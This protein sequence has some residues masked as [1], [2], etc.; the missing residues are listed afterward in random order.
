ASSQAR[1]M[2]AAQLLERGFNSNSN[3]LNWLTPSPGVVEAIEPIHEEPPNLREDM[4]GAHRK[5]KA[6]EDED[7]ALG[8]NQEPDSPYGVFPASL[9]P[10]AKGEGPSEDAGG[11]EPPVV[12][13][14]GPARKP[15]EP[16]PVE[17]F[18]LKPKKSAKSADSK[19]KADGKSKA[20]TK[21]AAKPV[22]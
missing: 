5:R 1:A 17:T 22:D 13:Y 9:R 14:T 19:A 6:T 8:V 7:E 2:K 21:T 10:K 11:R 18:D 3:A 12:V 15:G 16:I 20:G 4:C